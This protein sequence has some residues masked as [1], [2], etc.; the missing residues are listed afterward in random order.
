MLGVIGNL[1]A[2]ISVMVLL[3]KARRFYTGPNI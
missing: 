2:E 1:L 3:R